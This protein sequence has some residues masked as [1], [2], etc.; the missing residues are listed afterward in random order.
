MEKHISMERYGMVRLVWED[1][2]RHGST[3]NQQKNQAAPF[4]FPLKSSMSRFPPTPH[5]G[6]M[7]I[8]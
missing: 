5:S 4:L 8:A 3:E 7:D 1:M 2:A 6:A